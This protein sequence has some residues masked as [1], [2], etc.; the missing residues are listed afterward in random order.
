MKRAGN[1][2]E[3]ICSIDNLYLAFYKASKGKRFDSAVVDFRNNLHPNIALLQKQLSN[4]KISIGNYHYFTIFDPKIRQICAAEFTERIVHHAI[5]NVCHDFFERQLIYDTYATRPKKGTYAALERAKSAMKKNQYVVK[6]DFKKYFD[7]ISHDV[8]TIKLQKI[9]KDRQ[10]L[11]LFKQIIDSYHVETGRGIPIGN[12][13]SQ[14]FANYYLSEFDHYAKETL[15]IDTYI[16]YMDDILIFG[17][18]KDTLHLHVSNLN[19]KAKTELLLSFKPPVFALCKKG[20]SF[21]GYKLFPNKTLL[22]RMSKKRFL[23]SMRSS[24]NLLKQNHFDE[25]K[26][27]MKLFGFLTFA[28][29]AYSKRIRRKVSTFYAEEEN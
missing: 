14:Y 16:R 15:K 25:K 27:Q 20:I 21:L 18:E 4:G 8:L 3:K 28:K 23:K 9:F 24:S 1:L 13:T 12:L 10:L 11:N 26:I 22:N 19:E 17:N 5:M 6:L 7:S 2:M 29:Y